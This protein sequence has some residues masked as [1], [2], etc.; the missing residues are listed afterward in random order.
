MNVEII[1]TL[2]Q[3]STHLTS[4]ALDLGGDLGRDLG[5]DIGG[6]L[7]GILERIL[8]GILQL[9]CSDYLILVPRELGPEYK[10]R[11]IYRDCHSHGT[12]QCGCI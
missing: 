8:E 9:P 1:S 11:Q 4:I 3:F 7:Q 6:D 5:G 2:E 12:S 10:T